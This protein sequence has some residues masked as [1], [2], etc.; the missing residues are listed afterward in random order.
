MWLL[1]VAD[2]PLFIYIL[3]F[4]FLNTKLFIAVLGLKSRSSLRMFGSPAYSDLFNHEEG[5]WKNNRAYYPDD[6]ILPSPT[7]I[8]GYGSLIWRPG[9]LLKDF[10]VF[11][12][13]AKG[14]RRMFAQRSWDHR[15]T[16][17]F[18]GLVA[19]I[20]DDMTLESAGWKAS[21]E[22]ASV[23]E[24]VCYLIPPLRMKEVMDELDW[25]E[26][27]G[28]SRV[29]IDVIFSENTPHF[30]AGE[31]ASVVVFTG[32]PIN[33]NFFLPVISHPSE[34]D[35]TLQRLINIIAYAR[36]PSGANADYV[37]NLAEHLREV[38]VHDTHLNEL[39]KRVQLRLNKGSH[40]KTLAW[41][42]SWRIF[43]WGS[44]EY[45]IKHTIFHS[46]LLTMIQ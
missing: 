40:D 43:S 22:E 44:N 38:G 7:Y 25:R 9:D 23:C 33:P 11:H 45:G 8:F 30:Q 41:P 13:K 2:Y 6:Q 29:I 1:S 35:W 27:G 24:G 19:T 46:L 26:R 39:A 5:V 17:E 37:L 20:I 14:W 12:C 31:T 3:I 32:Q 28:Y 36:G 16:R 21:F 4:N 18:P 15:G 34:R 10:E 42:S